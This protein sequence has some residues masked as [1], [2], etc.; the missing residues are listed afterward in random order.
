MGSRHPLRHFNLS[1]TEHGRFL[2]A[3]LLKATRQRSGAVNAI[4]V[5]AGVADITLTIRRGHF[6]TQSRFDVWW[7]ARSTLCLQG[8]LRPFAF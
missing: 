8:R 5:I 3:A 1:L 6:Y 4:A 2:G 7:Q